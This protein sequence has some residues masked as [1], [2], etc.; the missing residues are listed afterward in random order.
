[1]PCLR[2][3]TC[4]IAL[5][6]GDEADIYPG[7]ERAIG[8]IVPQ[9]YYVPKSNV[10]SNGYLALVDAEEW[11]LDFLQA[12]KRDCENVVIDEEYSPVERV[13]EKPNGQRLGAYVRM[14]GG[15]YEFGELLALLFAEEFADS[16]AQ[17]W[18]VFSGQRHPQHDADEL[19]AIVYDGMHEL[20]ESQSHRIEAE[21]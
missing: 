4:F 18:L 7:A 12:Y 11:G 8:P 5:D 2:E 9:G 10:N 3:V 21:S 15:E 13:F 19:I 1:M 20:L 14:P 6:W 16:I 17:A